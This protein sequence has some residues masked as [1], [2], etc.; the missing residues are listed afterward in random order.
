MNFLTELYVKKKEKQIRKIEKKVDERKKHRPP[1]THT[2]QT[3]T[4]SK[5]LV[6]IYFLLAAKEE[7]SWEELT[8]VKKL[9]HFFLN[10]RYFISYIHIHVC[11]IHIYS[12]W[13]L[14]STDIIKRAD[15]DK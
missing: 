13:L 6:I 14:R 5:L 7:S 8:C 10:L 2:A 11:I 4:Q 9:K 1:P 12:S 3:Q 15:A